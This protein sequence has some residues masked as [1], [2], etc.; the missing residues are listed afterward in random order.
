M[1]GRSRRSCRRSGRVGRFDARVWCRVRRWGPVGGG[2]GVRGSVR[3]PVSRDGVS[4]HEGSV[5]VRANGSFTGVERSKDGREM[6]SPQHN[7]CAPTSSSERQVRKQKGVGVRATTESGHVD[8]GRTQIVP[9]GDTSGV[10]R[11]RT[12]TRERTGAVGRDEKTT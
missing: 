9:R 2:V 11:K 6:G 3:R 10:G 7:S 5:R 12:D 4:D 1:V 8:G